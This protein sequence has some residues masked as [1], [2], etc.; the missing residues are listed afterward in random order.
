MQENLALVGMRQYAYDVPIYNYAFITNEIASARVFIS[1]RGMA[2][3]FPLYVYPECNLYNGGPKYQ[4]EINIAPKILE[5]IEEAYGK[6]PSPEDIL[7]YIYAV[8]Y[9]NTYRVKYGEF[10][11]T[12]F[13][14]IPFCS[15]YKVFRSAA[16]F[17]RQLV[18]LHLMKS[19]RLDRP[20]TK[21]EGKGDHAV[22]Q[23][24]YEKEKKT[25]HINAEQ[26]FAPV[27]AEVWEYQIGGY[28]VMEKWLKDRKGRRL[29]L[30]EIR[31]Y[32]R[33]ATALKETIMLQGKI[34]EIYKHIEKK[35][36][37]S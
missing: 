15:D 17:G 19:D 36:V 9:S 29:F 11:K 10:L 25:I 35:Y 20:T 3:V 5:A 14:R 1:N 23:V 12:D 8:L 32:C 31:Q 4:R 30:D 2:S 24:A 6:R 26:H 7:Y 28:Q 34:D 37:K 33:I 16:K 27:P 21:F 13:P 22:K 18:E